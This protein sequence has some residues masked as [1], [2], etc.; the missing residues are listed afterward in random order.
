MRACKCAPEDLRGKRAF[1][2]EPI[3]ACLRDNDERRVRRMMERPM[4]VLEATALLL[5]EAEKPLAFSG[6]IADHCPQVASKAAWTLGHAAAKGCD[7]SVAEG[8]LNDGLAR[9]EAEVRVACAYAL[10]H[11]CRARGDTAGLA[12]LETHGDGDVRTGARL[13]SLDC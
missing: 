12:A 1:S 6:L 2:A 3:E 8:M 11:H 7:I 4:G 10:C 13:A 9:P 5:R